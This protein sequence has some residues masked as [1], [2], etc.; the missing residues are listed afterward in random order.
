MI[1]LKGGQQRI[2]MPSEHA[3]QACRRSMDVPAAWTD[4]TVVAAPPC[5]V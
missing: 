2:M 5:D 3:K 4:T 1:L